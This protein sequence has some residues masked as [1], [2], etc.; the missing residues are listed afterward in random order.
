MI[1]TSGLS[2]HW[3]MEVR[4]RLSARGLDVAVLHVGRFAP[5][6]QE[7]TDHI[8]AARRW[9]VVEDHMRHGGLADMAARVAG[10]QPDL[11]FGWPEN[12]TGGSGTSDELRR[13][14][15]LDG[16]TIANAI[17]KASAT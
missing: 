6:P 11:W 2:A 5:P 12:W 10:R 17:W 4:E 15:G 16:Q 3:A 1:V 14:C 13:S 8:Q 7:L 9:Y